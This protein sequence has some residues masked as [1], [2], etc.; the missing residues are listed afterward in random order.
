M[1]ELCHICMT[2]WNPRLYTFVMLCGFA[3]LR[4]S[5]A[6]GLNMRSV[7]LDT[8]ILHVREQYFCFE[9]KGGTTPVLKT[10]A[11]HRNIPMPPVLLAH[12]SSLTDLRADGYLFDVDNKN[13][14]VRFC[15]QLKNVCSV[16][17]DGNPR[18]SGD[19]TPIEKPRGEKVDFYVFP[20]LLRHTYATRCFEGG[21]DVKEVQYLMGHTSPKMTMEIYIHYTEQVRQ[22]DTA[23]KIDQAFQSTHLVAVGQNGL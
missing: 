4:E 5:E 20:H 6:L 7:D 21:L 14:Q 10:T 23:K 22:R 15:A 1:N 19:G 9:G 12:L 3:G 17:R 16:D 13:L 18:R 11:A 2:H 8:G